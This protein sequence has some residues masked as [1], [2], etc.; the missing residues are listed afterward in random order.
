M[1]YFGDGSWLR[2]CVFTHPLIQTSLDTIGLAMMIAAGTFF[3]KRLDVEDNV[4]HEYFGSEWE[5]WAKETWKLIPFV[6]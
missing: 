6:Y 1:A 3:W 4:L 5:E 2:E